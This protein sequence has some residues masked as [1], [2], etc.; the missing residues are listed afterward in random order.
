M[1]HQINA[2]VGFTCH[3]RNFLP[4]ML[5][6]KIGGKERKEE[7]KNTGYGMVMERELRPA[8]KRGLFS[9]PARCMSLVRSAK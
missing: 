3:T 5:G 6:K 9:V 4:F 2:V 7:D 1:I 8:I